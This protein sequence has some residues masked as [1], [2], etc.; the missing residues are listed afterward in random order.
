LSSSSSSDEEEP[1]SKRSS[2]DLGLEKD[3][4]LGPLPKDDPKL[5]PSNIEEIDE[6]GVLLLIT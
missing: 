3:L 6:L 4:E 5:K 1:K 2:I